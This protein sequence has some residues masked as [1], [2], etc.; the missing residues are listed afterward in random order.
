VSPTN[1]QSFWSRT[2]T[3]TSFASLSAN[4]TTMSK[5]TP[6]IAFGTGHSSDCTLPAEQSIV[7][8]S[9]GF[10]VSTAEAASNIAL[11]EKLEIGEV[12]RVMD[13]KAPKH[14]RKAYKQHGIHYEYCKLCD[15]SSDVKRAEKVWRMTHARLKLSR[16]KAVLL[17]CAQGVSRS[18]SC[19][20][21]H[22]ML[23]LR[24]SPERVLLDV[25]RPTRKCAAPNHAFPARLNTLFAASM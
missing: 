17:H 12:L 13:Y 2:T 10:W 15:S 4:T 9:R 1:K 23:T 7:C 16:K 21:Y 25:V 19:Y 14:L 5:N 3:L 22:F 6:F 24:Q 8:I 20:L 18:I 11:L